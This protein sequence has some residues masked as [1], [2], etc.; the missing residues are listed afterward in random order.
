MGHLCLNSK[1]ITIVT[2]NIVVSG[3]LQQRVQAIPI[4]GY[5]VIVNYQIT[6]VHNLTTTCPQNNQHTPI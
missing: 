5:R 1:A 4:I 6:Q 3:K 2:Y